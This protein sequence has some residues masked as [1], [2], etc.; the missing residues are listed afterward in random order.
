MP[1]RA[2]TLMKR[3]NNLWKPTIALKG[4]PKQTPVFIGSSQ[5][6]NYSTTGTMY[7]LLKHQ[8]N[9]FPKRAAPPSSTFDSASCG[10]VQAEA[11]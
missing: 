1:K 5:L 8:G 6:S 11:C 2:S 4:M 9:Y 7:H 3:T 10:T